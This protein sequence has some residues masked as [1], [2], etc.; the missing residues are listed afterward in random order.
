MANKPKEQSLVPIAGVPALWLLEITGADGDDVAVESPNTAAATKAGF[1]FDNLAETPEIKVVVTDSDSGSYEEVAF[2][3]KSKIRF[4]MPEVVLEGDLEVDS[5]GNPQVKSDPEANATG[6]GEITTSING[7]ALGYEGAYTTKYA[8]GGWTATLAALVA[9]KDSYFLCI[10][11]TALTANSLANSKVDGY[12]YAVVKIASEISTKSPLSLTFKTQK[13]PGANGTID[14][15]TGL[16]SALKGIA[17]TNGTIKLKRNPN[18]VLTPTTL[19]DADCTKL[20][21]GE[22]VLKSVAA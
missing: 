8:A 22:V 11:P 2:A 6:K 1:V 16:A 20:E 14:W 4:I 17:Y 5:S 12:A 10:I 19:E 7:G 9:K 21:A 18:V 3:D 15:S 13:Y